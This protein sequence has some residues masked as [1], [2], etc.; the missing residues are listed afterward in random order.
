MNA[1]NDCTTDVSKKRDVRMCIF[2]KGGRS[3]NNFC[4]SQL[5][6]FADLI[7]VKFADLLQFAD[8]IFFVVCGFAF[9]DLIIFCGLKTSAN[10]QMQD[11]SHNKH[12]LN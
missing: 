12:K 2:G 9:A 8:Y 6:K 5:H 3:A 4:K 11:F 7:F 10:P 1:L